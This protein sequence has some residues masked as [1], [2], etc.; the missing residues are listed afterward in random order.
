MPDG[1]RSIREAWAADA[2]LA[3][4]ID[5]PAG[6]QVRMGALGSGSD[7]TVFLDHLGLPSLDFGF[8]SGNGIYHSLY[9]THWFF[10]TYGDPDFTYGERL[11]EAVGLFLLRMADADVLPLDYASTAETIDRY[12]D[13]LVREAG[14]RN[15]T[16]DLDAVRAAT[17]R[18][19]ATAEALNAEIRRILELDSATL[20]QA[21]DRVRRMN[22]LLV[23]TERGFLRAEGLPD[24]PW[25]QHQ[26]YAPGFYTGYGV[27]TLPGVREAL[28]RDDQR[29]AAAM[30]VSLSQGLERARATLVSAIALAATIGRRRPPCAAGRGGGP[31]RR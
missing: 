29:L 14:Q 6:R 27:K 19:G 11:A 12:L 1:R 23:S 25:F 24:R 26:V 28:E 17:A 31:P 13:E 30:A 3:A 20:R 9:D 15:L 8:E 16:V 21:Q 7:Y 2:G 4:W 22:D 5:T 18:F 10:T